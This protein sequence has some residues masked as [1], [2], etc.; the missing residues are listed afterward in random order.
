MKDDVKDFVR[1]VV[2]APVPDQWDD[3]RSRIPRSDAQA[4]TSTEDTVR[5]RVIA[6][7]VA[8]AVFGAVVGAWTAIRTDPG[9][10]AGSGS[11]TPSGVQQTPISIPS[12]AY[13]LDRPGTEVAAAGGY[14]WVAEESKEQIQKLDPSTG[15]VVATI[16]MIGDPNWLATGDG[17][18][19]V[20]VYGTEIT[21]VV[22]IDTTTNESV[23]TMH[24]VSG[25]IV[26]TVEGLWG[27][28]SRTPNPDWMVLL[29]PRTGDV[30]RHAGVPT[31]PFEVAASG[32]SVW[33]L[34]MQAGTVGLI[35]QDGSVRTVSDRSSGS[36]LASSPAGV[37]LSAWRGRSANDQ[38]G[39]ATSAFASVDGQVQP[40]GDIYNF[41]PMVVADD[42]VWFVAGPH[43]G[44]I[45]GLCGM[46]TTDGIVDRCADVPVDLEGTRDPVAFDPTTNT[47]WAVAY[48]AP[49][50][51]EV[52]AGV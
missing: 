25:P 45:S 6:A 4:D 10:A 27:F 11:T 8:F 32:R 49:Q 39:P 9:P 7:T 31:Q 22:G 12:T 33:L 16:Q 41:R 15:T 3:I 37:Y 44:D 46:R 13:A 52:N 47:L 21:A 26:Q 14:I 42:R 17:V 28:E 19:W 23:L 24:G 18:L 48:D 34:D 51:F 40:F 30:I 43:D 36:W 50:L 20:G 1:L 29:D 2:A 5:R 35:S 38:N